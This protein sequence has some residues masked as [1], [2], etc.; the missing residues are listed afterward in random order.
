[1]D[2]IQVDVDGR[3]GVGTLIDIDSDANCKVREGSQSGSDLKVFAKS[4][5]LF[6]EMVGD[7]I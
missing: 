6:D 4:G 2:E 7:T 1:L 5:D 3:R